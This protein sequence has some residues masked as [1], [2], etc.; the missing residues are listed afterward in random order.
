M[1]RSPALRELDEDT[2]TASAEFSATTTPTLR[3]AINLAEDVRLMGE[4]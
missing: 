4:D 1:A 2:L 3:S